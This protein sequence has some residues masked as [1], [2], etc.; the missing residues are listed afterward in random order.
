VKPLALIVAACFLVLAVRSVIYW[1]R[2]HPTLDNAREELLFAAF[3]TGRAGTWAI[4]ATMFAVFGTI[5]TSGQ[6]YADEA[7]GASWLFIVFIALGAMQFLAAWFLRARDRAARRNG[8]EP[9]LDAESGP[10]RRP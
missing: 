8:D 4:A 7:R 9:P 2:H 5:S 10:T 3:V 1:M 6:P